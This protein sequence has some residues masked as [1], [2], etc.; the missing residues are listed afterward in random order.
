[1][2]KS[3]A[4]WQIARTAACAT[5]WTLWSARAHVGYEPVRSRAHDT[6]VQ[7][8]AMMLVKL[9]QGEAL[10]PRQL[11][12][13]FGV[14]LR[15]IQRDLNERFG[16]LPLEK[17]D[18]GYRMSPAFLGRLSLK[19]VE[20]FARLSGVMGLFPSLSVDFLRD[21][22]DSRLEPALVVKGHHYE[23]LRG[24][25]AQFKALEQAIVAQRRVR[26]AYPGS[27]GAKSYL[28]DPYKL[29]NQKGVWY[30]AARHADKL[31]TFSF[32]R[33]DGLLVTDERFE[34]EAQMLQR[35]DGEEGVWLSDRTMEVL[36]AVDADAAPYFRRRRLIANQKIVDE[37]DDGS[38]TVSTHIGHPN[39][40][41]PIIR[42]WIPHLRV[43]SPKEL[44]DELEAGL[45]VYLNRRPAAQDQCKA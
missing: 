12:E 41:L 11:A 20:R 15:T 19:D 2:G 33:I 27:S 37:R 39:Q 18:G 28:V 1:M 26:F 22:F 6:L 38:L 9:N 16:Y 31:K 30:L 10:E 17:V 45:E 4:R 14:N 3:N 40:V 36:I 35:I 44:Q 5:S 25:E 32:T 34:P 29:V 13:D 23:D 43:L 8:L 24:L 42:Y 7:R 21:I